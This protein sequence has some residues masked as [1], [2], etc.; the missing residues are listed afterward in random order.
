MAEK[1]IYD[2]TG[3]RPIAKETRVGRNTFKVERIKKPDNENLLKP[4][5]EE[6]KVTKVLLICILIMKKIE[7]N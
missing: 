3:K 6:E 4:G 5:E 1:V 2:K 7:K